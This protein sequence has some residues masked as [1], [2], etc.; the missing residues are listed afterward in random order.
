MTATRPFLIK[1]RERSNAPGQKRIGYR[2]G[3]H[4]QIMR[5]LLD[6]IGDAERHPLIAELQTSEDDDWTIALLDS[7]ATMAD[8][9]TFYQ[10]R[11]A[12]ESYLRTATERGSVRNLAR[13]VD[14][15]LR[16]GKAASVFL[17]LTLEDAPGAPEAVRLDKDLTVMSVP[18]P[19][20]QMQTFETAEPLTGWAEWNAIRPRLERE[21]SLAEIRSKRIARVAGTRG[22]IRP[23]ER[24]LLIS[25]AGAESLDADFFVQSVDVEGESR[26]TRITLGEDV[27]QRWP[28]EPIR[29]DLAI[30]SQRRPLLLDGSWVRTN[31]LTS[32]YRQ[33]NLVAGFAARRQSLR[34]LRRHLRTL[35]S[36][37]DT[38]NVDDASYGL[39]RFAARASIFG[40]NAPS[41]D[42]GIQEQYTRLW[43]AIL[44]NGE[45]AETLPAPGPLAKETEQPS[46]SK[47]K[48]WIFLDGEY[49]EAVAGSYLVIGDPANGA[50]FEAHE[51]TGNATVSRAKYGIASKVSRIEI[52]RSEDFPATFTVRSTQV[53]LQSERLTLALV[54]IDDTLGG[55]EIELDGPYLELE[56]GRAVAITGEREDLDGVAASEIRTI[57]R[58]ELNGGFT[59]L[60]LDRDLVHAF[61]RDTVTINANVAKATH[62]EAVELP[63][64]SGDGRKRGQRFRLPDKP[65]TYIGADT[66]SGTRAELE[67]RVDGIAWSEVARLRGKGSESAAYELRQNEDGSTTV[68]FGDGTH[69]ARLPTG[70]ENVTASFR[71]GSGLSGQVREN[72]LTL[73]GTRPQGL[74]AVTNPL[75]ARGAAD[76]ER[77]ED[78]RANAP[79]TVLTFERV[80]SLRD[81][82]DFARAQTPFAKAHAAWVWAGTKRLVFVTVA[83]PGGGEFA[84]DSDELRHLKRAFARHGD[85]HVPVIAMSYRPIFFQ[86]EARL[87]ILPGYPAEDVIAAARAALRTHFA[88]DR[89][90]FGE[91][92]TRAEVVSVIQ[93]TAG[94]D[95]ADLESLFV[96]EPANNARLTADVPRSGARFA[97]GDIPEPAQLLLL[98]PQ[99]MKLE[100]LP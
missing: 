56:E 92:V 16:P 44:G 73:P 68:Q 31:V 50:D 53:Y 62:G 39:Y 71:K 42:S 48:L 78:A 40:H 36:R 100:V 59:I 54:P 4:A 38:T 37:S 21:Q 13:H 84:S 52:T 30:L 89:R 7:F 8:V 87:K 94:V 33:A 74:K 93:E 19:G 9:L 98:D 2:L 79:L 28:Y 32:R 27:E 15:E 25:D 76:A 60:T 69:G 17:S 85:P 22:D 55:S 3:S 12:Q 23:G 26:T 95:Y 29:Y 57:E 72:T 5:A 88:F 11:I 49:P 63:I 34:S 81:F 47:T 83:G 1:P 66:P 24:I 58:L 96:D 91:P 45:A 90:H 43:H 14:Y 97:A 46:G 64:G 51:I 35:R 67:V 99:P 70:V 18:G 10:E 61:K 6:A 75:A 82:E 65:L 86:C 20:E 80:V 41:S 77:I